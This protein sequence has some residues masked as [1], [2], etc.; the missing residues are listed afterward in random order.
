MDCDMC[1]SQEAKNKVEVEGTT[2]NLCVNCSTYGKIIKKIQQP[3]I[4]KPKQKIITR[5]EESEIIQMITPNYSNLIKNKREKLKL[6]QE[7]L[8]KKIAEKVSLIHSLESGHT[9]PSISLARKL[10]K[11]LHIK[12]VEEYKEEY[13]AG[14]TTSAEITLGDVVKIRKR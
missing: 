10:E 2:L 7:E 3:V 14:K 12:L 1:G 4:E 8:A 5:P 11:F 13:K 6:K 9:K